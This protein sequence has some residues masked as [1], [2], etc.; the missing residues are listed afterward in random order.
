MLNAFFSPIAVIDSG[1]GGLKLLKELRRLYPSENYIYF[2]DYLFMPY[3]KKSKKTITKRMD[4]IVGMLIEK[5]RAKMIVVACN[6]A[7][8]SALTYLKS[9]YKV[10]IFGVLPKVYGDNCLVIAT[11]LTKKLMDD[12]LNS[13]FLPL[14]KREE[15]NH[16]A[17][18]SVPMLANFVENNFYNRQEIMKKIHI[19]DKKLNMSQY[20][21]IVLGCTHYEYIGKYFKK[22]FKE[23]KIISP[24]NQTLGAIKSS[25]ILTESSEKSLGQIFMLSSVNYKH[26]I[27][28]LYFA[29]EKL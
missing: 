6:T 8:I 21:A 15:L 26:V 19:L 23:K 3:G 14:R 11:S 5:Y 13:Y 24:I 7:S 9:K 20:N 16:S 27:E 17:R 22:Y 2:A 18:I 4:E 29:Y 28:K 10:P 25:K 1:I 12:N